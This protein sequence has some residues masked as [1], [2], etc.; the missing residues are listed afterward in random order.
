MVQHKER[1]VTMPTVTQRQPG[2]VGAGAHTAPF[3]EAA[4]LQ[5]DVSTFLE[6]SCFSNIDLKAD[7]TKP[8]LLFQHF[9]IG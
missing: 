8:S 9:K 4:I 5:E 6:F 1:A 3:P 2:A 7:T